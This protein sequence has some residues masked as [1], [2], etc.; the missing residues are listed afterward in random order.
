MLPPT[1]RRPRE[2]LIAIADGYFDTV[3]LNDGQIFTHFADDRDRLENGVSTTAAENG[4]V[5]SASGCRAQLELGIFRIKKRIRERRVR[6][7][8]EA[9]GIVVASAVL[10]RP[11]ASADFR[12]ADGNVRSIVIPYPHS[13][14]VVD[15]FRIENG[16]IAR[17][18]GVSAF[19]PY[20]MPP[21][22]K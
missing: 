19:M 5:K 17:V 2:R 13:Q 8:D 15:V 9:R 4:V 18:E 21:P 1:E 16:R 20:G 6:A 11:A 10:D 22:W 12:G 14:G 3:Q 7:I